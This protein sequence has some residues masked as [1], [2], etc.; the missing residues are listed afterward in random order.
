MSYLRLKSSACNFHSSK[1]G[2]G[3]ITEVVNE[4][5]NKCAVAPDRT[6]LASAANAVIRRADDSDTTLARLA[7]WH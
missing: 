3:N 5:V 2:G 1:Y 7:K 6:P 4:H